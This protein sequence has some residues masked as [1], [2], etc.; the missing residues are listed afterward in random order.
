MIGPLEFH[1]D[2]NLIPLFLQ[3]YTDVSRRV[4]G[5]LVNL[6][7]KKIQQALFT[8]WSSP[9]EERNDIETGSKIISNEL[10]KDIEE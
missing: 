9:E 6:T 10:R 4:S 3:A 1:I 5:P 2:K 8:F 7:I